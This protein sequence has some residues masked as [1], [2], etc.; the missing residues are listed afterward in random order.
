LLGFRNRVRTALWS[1]EICNRILE[2]DFRQILLASGDA[3]HVGA[4]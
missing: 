4:T 2:P 1:S 3:H